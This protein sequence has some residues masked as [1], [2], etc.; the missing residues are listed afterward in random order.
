MSLLLGRKHHKGISGRSGLS[1]LGENGR[2]DDRQIAL[3]AVRGRVADSPQLP[4]DVVSRE[5]VIAV[6]LAL[7]SWGATVR[8]ACSCAVISHA[9]ISIG[10]APNIPRVWRSLTIETRPE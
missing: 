9:S 5:V 7:T 4:G 2:G 3:V 8:G 1:I 6:P 10:P